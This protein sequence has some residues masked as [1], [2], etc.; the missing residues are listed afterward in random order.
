MRINAVIYRIGY[1]NVNKVTLKNVTLLVLFL[2]MDDPLHYS[3]NAHSII[4]DSIQ[5]CCNAVIYS[6][7]HKRKS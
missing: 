7:G 6:I 4:V 2:F 5:L 3:I 1:K